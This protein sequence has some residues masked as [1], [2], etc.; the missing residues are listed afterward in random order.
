MGSLAGILD[1]RRNSLAASL[2]PRKR[3][4]RILSIPLLGG[5]VNYMRSRPRKRRSPHR[6]HNQH[7]DSPTPDRP[8][9]QKAKVKR[10][11]ATAWKK[12]RGSI[13]TV[14]KSDRRLQTAIQKAKQRSSGRKVAYPVR[15]TFRNPG[16]KSR[17]TSQRLRRKR[18]D[19]RFAVTSSTK[20]ANF[21]TRAGI[22]R[23][24]MKRSVWCKEKQSKARVRRFASKIERKVLEKTGMELRPQKSGKQRG[25]GGGCAEGEGSGAR[26]VLGGGRVDGDAA[27]AA[28]R[29]E[30]KISRGPGDGKRLWGPRTLPET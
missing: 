5:H 10:K 3:S 19:L 8:G 23:D 11:V 18:E 13:A 28:R 29:V 6:Q 22:W 4:V 14:P 7:T 26:K 17:T 24:R 30:E 20:L 12:F 27:A 1:I 15:R 2:Q 25:S 9:P 21:I 16:L